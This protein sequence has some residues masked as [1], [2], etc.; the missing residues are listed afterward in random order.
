LPSRYGY[1][2]II[3]H[4]PATCNVSVA[5]SRSRRRRA[6]CG[7]AFNG[8]AAGAP[9]LYVFGIGPRVARQHLMKTTRASGVEE[10]TPTGLPPSTLH[11]TKVSASGCQRLPAGAS[12]CQRLPADASGPVLPPYLS[13]AL[14]SISEAFKP[15]SSCFT[16]H[17]HIFALFAPFTQS[18]RTCTS[19]SSGRIHRRTHHRR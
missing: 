14:R 15:P 4:A 1:T 17:M 7:S 5:T 13:V 2:L 18:P 3:Y 12:G 10:R 11:R 8:L 9:L 6:L 19:L 16:P